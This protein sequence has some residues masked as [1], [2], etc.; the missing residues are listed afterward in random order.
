M[1]LW[2]TDI[3][4]QVYQHCTLSAVTIFKE[5]ILSLYNCHHYLQETATERNSERIHHEDVKEE[6]E[7]E[8]KEGGKRETEAYISIYNIIQNK[9]IFCKCHGCVH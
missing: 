1:P 6:K 4:R 2:T 7:K 8:T 9:F 5:R 3:C